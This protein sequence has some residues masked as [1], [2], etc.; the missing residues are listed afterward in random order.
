MK[1]SKVGIAAALGLL[2]VMLATAAV[3]TAASSLRPTLG[4]PNHKTVHAGT[5]T[6]KVKDPA[7]VARHVSVFVSI[8]PTRKT[9][10][11]G[12]LKSG[13][14]VAKR[15]NFVKLKR[16]KGHP[17]WWIYPPQKEF[18]FP[19]YW[20]TTPGKLYW[21]AQHVDCDHFKSCQALSKIGSF[22]IVG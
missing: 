15:C 8:A 1:R 19:G 16:W 13:C 5:F 18:N 21:Q 17:G 20:Q 3:A 11:D 14:S 22:R 12:Q 10:K 7:A 9:N 2:V 6:L 4:P